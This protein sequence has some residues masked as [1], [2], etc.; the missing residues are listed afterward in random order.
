MSHFVGKAAQMERFFKLSFDLRERAAH[1]I[2]LEFVT[3]KPSIHH[4]TARSV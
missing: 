2:A 1:A 4:S 3:A